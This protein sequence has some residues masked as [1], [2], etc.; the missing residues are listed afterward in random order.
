MDKRIDV[1][2]WKS[3]HPSFVLVENS[4]WGKRKNNIGNFVRDQRHC[5]TYSVVMLCSWRGTN[6]KVF[7]CTTFQSLWSPF[8][9]PSFNPIIFTYILLYVIC[10]D[11]K[12]NLILDECHWINFW[13][14]NISI[15]RKNNN[16]IAFIFMSIVIIGTWWL[17]G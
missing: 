6:G 14:Q 4:G 13:T 10:C 11:W 17:S 12:K 3:A 2:S 8:N 1:L 15:F 16:R 7:H 5:S 9:I